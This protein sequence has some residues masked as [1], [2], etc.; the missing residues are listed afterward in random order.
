[1]NSNPVRKFITRTFLKGL[2]V[3]IPIAV[4]IYVIIWL[5][6]G[7]EQVVRKFLAAVLPEKYYLPGLGLV[8]FATVIF[9][10]GLLMYP[11]I[12]RTFLGKF[13]S[14]LRKIPFLGTVYSP[15]KDLMNLFGGSDMAKKLGQPVMIRIPNTNM[16][17]LGFIT[18]KDSEGLPEGFLPEDHIVVYVQWSSQVGGY[19]FIVPRDHVRPV[20]ITVEEGMRWAITAGL[21]AP[22]D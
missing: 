17:T 12:T 5:A 16:E 6:N 14:F 21:S 22:K 1:M 15:V 19:C 10:A 4:A 13:D 11:W 20:N 7:A 18:K 3:V 9:F 2:S 8:V